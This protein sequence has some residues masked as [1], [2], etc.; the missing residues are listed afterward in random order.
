[1]KP[2][3]GVPIGAETS[4]RLEVEFRPQIGRLKRILSGQVFDETFG[5]VPI[6]AETSRRLEVEF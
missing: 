2:S 5:G 6:G 1:M 3:G 4:R